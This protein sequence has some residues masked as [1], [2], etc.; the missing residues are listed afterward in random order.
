[1]TANTATFD[2][3]AQAV[4]LTGRRSLRQGEI[5]ATDLPPDGG[6]LTVDACGMCGSDW[7]WYA[8]RDVP[9]PMVLGH[10]IVGTVSAL[11]GSLACRGDLAIGDRVV[12]EEAVPCLSCSLCRSGRHRLCRSSGRYG[13]TAVKRSPGL[14]GG[15][16]QTVFLDRRATVHHVPD[17]LD[18]VLAALFIP[19]ANGLSWVGDAAQLRAGEAVLVLGPGQHGLGS[20]AAA[21]RLGAGHVIVAGRHGDQ[22]RLAAARAL[23]ADVVVNI[24]EESLAETVLDLTGGVGVDV[25][26]DT[27][28]LSTSALGAAVELSAVGGRII[29][30]GAKG[31]QT[32]PLDTDRLHRHELVVRGVAARESRAI[33]AALA[34]LASEPERFQPFGGLTVGL[35]NV[36]DAL[37]ALGGEGGGDRPLHA[38]VVPG[39][40]PTTEAPA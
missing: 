18:P 8:L 2:V 27:T 19:I 20:A 21:R 11:W 40:T 36:E 31:G 25:T 29:V 6:W 28:P 5:V 26:I 15:Y 4:L 9:A 39:G 33:D 34:W 23:G 32:S 38:V 14:W 30:A 13:A 24:D 35:N 12:L 7:N 16:A 3:A 37:V 10:E 17:G 22:A 1:M